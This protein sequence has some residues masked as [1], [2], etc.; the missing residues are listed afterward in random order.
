M[1]DTS[2]LQAIG[3]SGSSGHCA[4]LNTHCTNVRPTGKHEVA[5]SF[6]NNTQT[7]STHIGI[8][9]LSHLP[10]KVRTFHLLPGMAD[11]F[12]TS[13]GQLC[14]A[15]MTVVLTNHMICVHNNDTLKILVM[16]GQCSKAEKMWCMNLDNTISPPLRTHSQNNSAHELRK[17]KILSYSFHR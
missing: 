4:C 17:R 2:Q 7:I 3:D 8:L 11:K 14:N 1:Q 13:L 16:E 9:P 5:I 6:P 10:L 15:R 12:L